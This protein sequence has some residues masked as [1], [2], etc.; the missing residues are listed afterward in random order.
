[1]SVDF[2][3]TSDDYAT[4]RAGFPKEFFDC[5]EDLGV[6]RPGGRLVIAHFDWI[7]EPGSVVEMTEKLIEKHN[8]EWRWGGRDGR[9]PKW[10]D[11][12][13]AAGFE[14]EENFE[15]DQDVAYSHAAWR[16]RV[17]A[18][19]GVG[20]SLP[21]VQIEAFDHEHRLALEIEFA[22]EPLKAPHRVW[23]LIAKF[24]G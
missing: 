16:G 15:F 19:A 8:P 18:S 9:Y 17:R 4:Y 24:A 10:L 13:Q 2:G 22:S 12:M 7:A 20:A 23:A 3:R 6:L 1:M 5:L 14:T 11:V 21:P